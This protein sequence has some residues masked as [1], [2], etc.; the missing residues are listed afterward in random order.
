MNVQISFRLS[1][2]SP[3]LSV[4]SNDSLLEWRKDE[5]LRDRL[6]HPDGR[7]LTAI[8]LGL[9]FDHWTKHIRKIVDEAGIAPEEVLVPPAEHVPEPRAVV[10]EHRGAASEE[11]EEVF[12]EA[13]DGEVRIVECKS[14]YHF[15]YY[16]LPSLGT[17]CATRSQGLKWRRRR[18]R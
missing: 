12:H 7:T 3:S 5:V 9:V 1:D 13:E 17:I 4:L 14:K 18:Q 10:E 8:G 11:E 16:L 6:L 15:Q 2:K